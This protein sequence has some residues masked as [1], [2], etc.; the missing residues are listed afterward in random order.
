MDASLATVVIVPRERFSLAARSLDN[1]LAS[2][3]ADQPLVYVDGNSPPDVRDYIAR[4]AEARP[5]QLLRS[6]SYLSPN[7]A[8]NWAL[9]HIQSKYVVFIDNDALASPGWLEALVDCAESTGAWVVGP[10][11]CEREPIGE[12]IHMAGG[13]ARFVMQ[14]GRRVFYE[15]HRHYGKKLSQFRPQ[16]RREPVEQIEFHCVLVRRDAL[17]RM[18]RLDEQLLSAAE[19]TDLCLLAREAGGEVYL[20]PDSAVTYVPPPPLEKT[21]L[22]YFMLRWSHA[23]NVASIE[24]FRAKWKLDPDDPGLADL[25]D[26]CSGHRRIAWHSVSRAMRVLGRKPAR[27]L[28]N[29]VMARL[30]QAIN[31][32]RFPDAMLAAYKTHAATCSHKET[33]SV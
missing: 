32:R 24:R 15:E 16:L 18:G 30:E 10:V 23:W 14:D 13:D 26:W 28:E 19:H 33:L 8:R 31:R 11:Y 25:L 21:D 4:A 12:R 5:F 6:D 27:W 1:I 9:S 29:H 20:E 7:Q 3:Q 17:E 22:P 2:L